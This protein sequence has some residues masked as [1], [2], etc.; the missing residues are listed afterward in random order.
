MRPNT[1]EPD[2][3]N[4]GISVIGK[5]A[6]IPAEVSVGRNVVIRPRADEESFAPFKGQVPSGSTVD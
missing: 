1:A 4:T 3:I 2:R 5:N 6:H